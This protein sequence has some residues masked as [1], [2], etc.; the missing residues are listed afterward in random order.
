MVKKKLLAVAITAM[1]MVTGG[2]ALYYSSQKKIETTTQFVSW[3]QQILIEYPN[4]ELV[5]FSNLTPTTL[6]VLHNGTVRT[7]IHYIL[8]AKATS[9]QYRTLAIDLRS[10]NVTFKC[11]TSPSN[12]YIQPLSGN[13]VDVS[14][15]LDDTWYDIK[16]ITISISDIVG[17]LTDGTY[18]LTVTPIGTIFYSA[19]NTFSGMVSPLP[20]FSDT[21]T[22]S[23]TASLACNAHGPY[24]AIL[25]NS[26]TCTGTATGGT[27]PYTWLWD[28]GDSTTS[29][30][31]NPSHTYTTTGTKTITLTV[32]DSASHTATDS[33]TA[34]ISP[35]GGTAPA[36]GTIWEITHTSIANT[37]ANT[38]RAIAQPVLCDVT[39]DG[40]QDIFTTDGYS[41][42]SS[43]LGNNNGQVWCFNG[44]TGATIWHYGP[45]YDIGNHA[46]MSIHD[47]DGDGK[48]ELLV[49]GYH[50][51]ISFNAENGS[52][53]WSE[54]DRAYRH[55]KP[56]VVLKLGDTVYVYTC[57]N[58]N[59]APG[60]I[61]K[62]LGSTGAV[63]AQSTA[64][65]E[66]PCYGGLSAADI[67]NDGKIEILLGDE[68]T[69]V[70]L[71]CF[72]TNCNMLWSTGIECSTQAPIIA[73][74]NGDG[75]LD[76]IVADQET[77]KICVVN[78]ASPT[79]ALL[80]PEFG[81]L[82]SDSGDIF[83]A[84]VYDLHG[85]GH[86]EYIISVS[87]SILVYDLTTKTLDAT[88]A[89]PHSSAGY[90]F[91]PII[92]N[93]YGDSKMEIV[94]IYGD[95]GIDV[96]DSSY[97]YIYNYPAGNSG[98]GASQSLVTVIADINGDGYNEIVQLQ[99]PHWTGCYKSVR[100][101]QTSG[102]ATSPAATAKEQFYTYKRGQ[103][104]QY[105]AYND[106]D[107]L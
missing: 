23:G 72:D 75:Y 14:I 89:N 7:A 42:N 107:L 106:P 104:S 77:H 45:I 84:S 43:G 64:P 30:L 50:I 27:S 4:H 46:V 39:G 82:P 103:V 98:T 3:G 8:S 94:N 18:T 95:Y 62:R 78:G 90:Y 12:T 22:I 19:D 86:L 99:D 9:L 21:L 1:L 87:G 33:S 16:D 54:I 40:I 97:K 58:S 67:N 85:D 55:D 35:S 93:V 91:P 25:G 48:P 34:T 68:N 20:S 51:T 26:I 83:T 17:S 5:P 105:V 101:I 2:F 11:G 92:A 56:A 73:D 53:K 88:I 80:F 65:I 102:A 24:T 79:G 70:G 37:G 96:F 28:F 31:Q 10:C 74:V 41:D 29:T 61:V 57:K 63:V 36:W 32:T 13:G 59:G 100:V 38:D 66:G 15:P 60:G 81:S 69:G 52:I 44:K 6:S 76:V 47:L 49:C 71:S